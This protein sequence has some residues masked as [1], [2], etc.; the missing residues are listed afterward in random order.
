VQIEKV[1]ERFKLERVVFVGDRGMIT[2]ARIR[3]ELRPI[4]GLDWISSLRSPQIRGLVQQGSLQLSLFDERDLAEI[5]HPD[6][7]GERLVACRNPLLAQERA[8]KRDELLAIT[9]RKLEEV[10]QATLRDKRALRGKDRIGIRVGRIL[11]RTKMG[12]HFNFTITDDAFTYERNTESI[13]TEAALD[14]IYIVR[15]SVKREQMSAE[16]AVTAY[17]GL[18]VVERAFRSHKVELDVRPLYH[19]LED[20]V[21]A[22]IFLC[23]LAYYVEWH[24][25]VALSPMLFDDEDP[26][27][28]GLQRKSI[29]SP[30]QPSQSAKRKA[31]TK[32]TDDGLP[33]HSFKTLLDDL[34]TQTK[35]TVENNAQNIQFVQVT[36]LTP[37]QEKAFRLL[38]VDPTRV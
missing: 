37:L 11:A 4:E 30:A 26:H 25:R 13:A 5:E 24:M 18:A 14:G 28:A 29:V 10:R 17:K 9:E 15:T 31:S 38:E 35:N 22:H 27:A 19:R 21:R 20:R 7:P 32:R 34:A 36:R 33:V 8:R 2:E 23:M 16:E 12:K 1:R 3:E 6:Y